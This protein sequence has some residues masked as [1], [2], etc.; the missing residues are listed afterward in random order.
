MKLQCQCCGVEREFL[1]GNEAFRAGWDAPPF[2]TTHICCDLC[3]AVC[4]V[5]GASHRM[6]HTLWDKEGRPAEFTVG[7]CGTDEHFAKH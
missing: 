2:F 5:L 1:D 7:K 6:A 4:V 3:P